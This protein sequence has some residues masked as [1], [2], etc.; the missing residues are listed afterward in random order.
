[1]K[2]ISYLS[3]IIVMLIALTGCGDKKEEKQE[4]QPTQSCEERLLNEDYSCFIGTYTSNDT[5]YKT[6]TIDKDGVNIDY[7]RMSDGQKDGRAKLED[8]KEENGIYI[9]KYDIGYFKGQ[10]SSNFR[11]VPIGIDYETKNDWCEKCESNEDN[12]R[13]EKPTEDYDYVL[14][15][16]YYTTDKEKVRIIASGGL[17][18][19]II[20]YKD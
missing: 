15:T 18:G 5:N 16:C 11:I 8:I 4:E 19:S 9:L 2:K 6:I 1:M 3:L 20:Y 13:Y 17:G 7:N 10:Q 12:C 14:G